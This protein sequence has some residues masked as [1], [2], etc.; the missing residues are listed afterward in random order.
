PPAAALSASGPEPGSW[1][2]PR[3]A[4]LACPAGRVLSAAWVAEAA[5][6]PGSTATARPA[7]GPPGWPCGVGGLSQWILALRPSP[8]GWVPKLPALQGRPRRERPALF[9]PRRRA[10]S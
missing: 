1:L 9:R 10:P 2:I 7:G 8:A 4:G 3:P 5:R 6:L